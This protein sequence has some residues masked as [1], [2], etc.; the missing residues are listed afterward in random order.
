VWPRAAHALPQR[1][2]LKQPHP[3]HALTLRCGAPGGAHTCPQP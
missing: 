3:P 2:A 1:W